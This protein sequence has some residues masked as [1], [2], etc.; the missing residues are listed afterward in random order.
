M[1]F[2][3]FNLSKETLAGLKSGGYTDATEIQEKTLKLAL[4]GRDICA[5]AKTGS[6][7]T[8]AFI[9]PLLECLLKEQWTQN[10]G[11]G[12]LVITP[13]RE[14]AYQ[15]FEVL[16]IVGQNHNFSA[17]LTIGGK[18]LALERTRINKINIIICT[19]GRL[20]Q[21]MD[22]NP[23]FNCDNLKFLVIDEADRI[24]DMGFKV[25][26]DSVIKF[27]PKD[28]QCLLFS[29]TL[30]N[31]VQ[32]LIRLSL[33]EPETIAVDL[34]TSTPDNLRQH[35]TVINAEQKLSFLWSFI[36][37]HKKSKV[38]VFIAT[39]K[40]TRFLHRLLSRMQPGISI[41][42]LYGT[43]HQLKRMDVYNK[44]ADV[45]HC[46]LLATD[47]AA[48]GL[49]FPDV[50]WV[51]QLDCPDDVN[52]YIHRAGRTARLNKSGRSLMVLMPNE[53]NYILQELKR[54]NVPIE[55]LPT[56]PKHLM[57]IENKVES[58]LAR[59]VEL[60]EEAKRAFKCYLKCLLNSRFRHLFNTKS[61]DLNAYAKSLGLAVTPRVRILERRSVKRNK[62]NPGDEVT[63]T[64]SYAMSKE[65]ELSSDEEDILRPVEKER[66]LPSDDGMS[67]GEDEM[68]MDSAKKKLK[69][70]KPLTKAKLA[71]KLIKKN[72]KV[73]RHKVFT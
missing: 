56:K 65:Y 63:V 23:L 20:L 15:I 50:D 33:K 5:S 6:G 54:N 9:V 48:R 61:I 17:A 31:S 51:V 32:D 62:E 55:E 28:R 57:Y 67:D 70:D 3:E 12:A 24:L 45:R 18:D 44:F 64:K 69:L 11:L 72:I 47:I 1:L 46:V 19:P 41:N 13:T 30:T 29:A 34:P 71:K 22:E 38:L 10:D 36:K 58:T 66:V 53:R 60:K 39:C 8:L 14:L 49:D 7:K 59:D 26:M 16:R 73:S 35:Y 68:T 4:E 43:M 27:L 37:H 42:A 21:H 2:K 25:V 40:Q 52:S